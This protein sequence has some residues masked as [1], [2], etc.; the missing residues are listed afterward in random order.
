MTTFSPF[1]GALSGLAHPAQSPG[2]EHACLL[3]RGRTTRVVHRVCSVPGGALLSSSVAVFPA[4]FAF[5]SFRRILRGERG[6]CL[7]ACFT[8]VSEMPSFPSRT[9]HRISCGQSPPLHL[10]FKHPRNAVVESLVIRSSRWLI[11]TSNLSAPGDEVVERRKLAKTT[12]ATTLVSRIYTT[13][14][15]YSDRFQCFSS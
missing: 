14:D 10:G 4:Q 1:S 8:D 11:S 7:C 12:S 13:P 5:C 9:R 2:G 15:N 3:R 6:S